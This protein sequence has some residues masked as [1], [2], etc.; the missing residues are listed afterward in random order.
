LTEVRWTTSASRDLRDIIEWLEDE[1][2]AAARRIKE[3]VASRTA[4]LEDLPR[5]G[6][7]GRVTGTRELILSRTA[8]LV[9]YHLEKGDSTAVI[10]RVIHARRRWPPR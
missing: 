3:I 5:I 1:S 2:P 7:P 4:Q 6:R 8:Y 9:I 10:D